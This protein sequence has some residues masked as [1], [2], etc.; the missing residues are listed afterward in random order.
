MF[1]IRWVDLECVLL[2]LLKLLMGLVQ[3]HVIV[4]TAFPIRAMQ[5]KTVV[6][7]LLMYSMMP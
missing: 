6:S 5:I 1:A 3:I 7:I 4:V 2:V